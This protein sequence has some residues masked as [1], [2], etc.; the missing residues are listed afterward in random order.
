MTLGTDTLAALAILRREAES[1]FTETLRFYRIAKVNDA[2]D[3]PIESEVDVV[4]TRGRVKFTSQ[5]VSPNQSG[6]QLVVV[7]QRRVDVGVD[8]TPDVRDGDQ[9]QVTGSDIDPGL[10]GRRFRVMGRP[11]SG[12]VTAWR[13]PVSEVS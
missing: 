12:T 7:Q 5:V 11:D 2:N 6:A 13:Y 10:V 3:V 9:V 8:A 4:T 1:R